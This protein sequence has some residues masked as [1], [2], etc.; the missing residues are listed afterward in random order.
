MRRRDHFRW[1]SSTQFH[2]VV[3]T[4][5]GH[6][7]RV[8]SGQPGHRTTSGITTF[9]IDN[10]GRTRLVHCVLSL[11][12]QFEPWDRSA[13]RGFVHFPRER[14]FRPIACGSATHVSRQRLLAEL[15]KLQREW[16]A[17]LF[18]SA[19]ITQIQAQNLEPNGNSPV[20]RRRSAV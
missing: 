14:P 15:A 3:A 4:T 16:A 17:P 1:S 20:R 5:V 13:G 11:L 6:G 19:A 10:E 7:A 18:T 12:S 8:E 2:M 9:S